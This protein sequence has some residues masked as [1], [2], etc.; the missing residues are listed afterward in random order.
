MWWLQIGVV[1]GVVVGLIAASPTRASLVAAAGTALGL[2]VGP[3]K[4]AFFP[5][6][7]AELVGFGLIASLIA[8]G[9]GATVA[10]TVRKVP[11]SARV[12]LWAAVAILVVNLWASALVIDAQKTFNP[13]SGTIVPSFNEQLA[14][15]IPAYYE[16]S[17]HLLYLRTYQDVR[18]GKPYYQSFRDNF[19]RWSGGRTPNTV[20]NIRSPLI[21]WFWAAFP[22]P[23]WIVYSFLVLATACVGM[24]PFFM[25]G[26]TVKSPLAIPAAAALSSY[27]LY[28][29]YQL[30]LLTTEAWAV[31]PALMS[32]V[33]ASMAVTSTRWRR[34]T[35]IAAVLAAVAFGVRE[36]LV[37][38]PLAGF[39][40]ALVVAGP[41]RRFRSIAWLAG[42]LAGG[43]ALGVHYWVARSVIDTT[44]QYQGFVP[45]SFSRMIDALVFATDHLGLG[46]WFVLTLAA[47][48]VLGA[49]L[50]PD[51]R[52]RILMGVSTITPLCAFLVVSNAG[53]DARVGVSLNYWGVAVVPLLYLC[54]PIVF[55][56]LPGST[57]ERKTAK[58]T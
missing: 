22:S 53:R 38:V 58:A 10:W 56:L 1:A 9:T 55:S 37:F 41:Q 42:L 18:A 14:G 47:L 11:G 6:T 5:P 26:T 39:V 17:D 48:G 36:T 23:R 29:P 32:V 8:L 31:M 57:T 7:P 28:F 44:S 25:S 54:I 21:T 33:C 49:L 27:F 4:S 50:I 34:L 15:N 13:M 46:G 51:L 40:S 52:L 19:V 43:A 24:T 3:V 16:D 20:L 2:A 35:V 12:L 30:T 45:G